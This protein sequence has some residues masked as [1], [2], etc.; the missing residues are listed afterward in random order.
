MRWFGES[1]T[2]TAQE[3]RIS[4]KSGAGEGLTLPGF[5][6]PKSLIANSKWKA[7]DTS[8]SNVVA[9]LRRRSVDSRDVLHT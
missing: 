4:L 2:T 7:R 6:F 1:D 9:K 8:H 5:G 3:R